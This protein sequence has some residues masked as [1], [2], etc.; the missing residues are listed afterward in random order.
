M[1]DDVE[2]TPNSPDQDRD[3]AVKVARAALARLQG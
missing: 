3:V 1:G 2:N